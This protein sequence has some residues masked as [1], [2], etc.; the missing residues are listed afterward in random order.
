MTRAIKP[1]FLLSPGNGTTQ[2]CTAV[3]KGQKPAIFQPGDVTAP[4]PN[5]ANC[6][7]LKLINLPGDHDATEIARLTRGLKNWN[8]ASPAWPTRAAIEKARPT[9]R[10]SLLFI[11]PFLS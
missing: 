10:N 7:W 11:F 3:P 1:L 5:V 9:A 6:P 2:V 8:R 4:A